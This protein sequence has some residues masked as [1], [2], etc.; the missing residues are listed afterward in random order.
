MILVMRILLIISFFYHPLAL[1]VEFG[2]D[3]L[4]IEQSSD[5]S[6]SSSPQQ[7]NDDSEIE[8][9]SEDEFIAP[10]NSASLASSLKDFGKI[11]LGFYNP[12]FLKRDIRPPQA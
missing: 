10:L 12:P 7:E 6:D 1:S 2:M 9:E 5:S 11:S 4:T 8:A 3:G